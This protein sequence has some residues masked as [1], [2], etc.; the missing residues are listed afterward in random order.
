MFTCVIFHEHTIQTITLV[1]TQIGV[2]DFSTNFDVFEGADFKSGLIFSLSGL[3]LKLWP[4][5]EA[6]NEF[7][8]YFAP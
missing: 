6:K 7:L 4:K 1:D 2:F 5:N 8:R 3:D